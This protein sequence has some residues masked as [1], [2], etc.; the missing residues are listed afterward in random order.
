MASADDGAESEI[1]DLTALAQ[2]GWALRR[3]LDYLDTLQSTVS[4][5][6]T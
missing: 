3:S 5:I 2:E 1:S 4:E 6:S